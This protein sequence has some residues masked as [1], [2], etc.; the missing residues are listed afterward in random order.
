MSFT[1]QQP[2]TAAARAK[3]IGALAL[4]A[5]PRHK[6]GQHLPR[7]RCA[8]A[9]LGVVLAATCGVA[10]AQ[11]VVTNGQVITANGSYKIPDGVGTVTFEATGA[12]GG[13]GGRAATST[14][15]GGR[16]G[17]G[18][19]VRTS[20]ASAGGL[21]FAV[22]VGSGGGAGVNGSYSS[23][24]YCGTNGG[25][26]TAT[27][28]TAN[29]ATFVS[30]AGGGGGGRAC[31]TNGTTTA[32][33]PGT[34][35]TCGAGSY[36]LNDPSCTSSS[37]N[38][39]GAGAISYPP[40]INLTA[41]ASSGSAGSI[42]VS[43]T[44]A[45]QT[46]A[47]PSLP[48][49]AVLGTGVPL[50]ATSSF[51]G[52]TFSYVG[53]TPGVC[54]V[55]N[56]QLTPTGWGDCS[57]TVQA[58]GDSG[59]N[60][61]SQSCTASVTPDYAVS[62]TVT[63]LVGAGAT[64][65]IANNGAPIAQAGNGQ[66]WT[67]G[68][69][70]G[71]YN[72]TA[73]APGHI[74]QVTNGSGTLTG[75]MPQAVTGV[76][77]A[78]TPDTY[79]LSGTISGAAGPLELQV[80]S[81]PHVLT[82]SPFTLYSVLGHGSNYP[83]S[84]T[85]PATQ[86][87]LVSPSSTGIVNGPVSNV[88]I[89]CGYPLNVAVSGLNES[90]TLVLQNNGANG[91]TVI[92]DGPLSFGWLPLGEAYAISVQTQ[93]QGQT[94]TVDAASAS[95]AM[96][97][98]L[99]VPVVCV[100]N[101]GTGDQ[102]DNSGTWT[103]PPGV[104]RVTI[105]VAG[106]GGGGGA[107]IGALFGSA[108]GGNGGN[109]GLATRLNLPVTPGETFRFQVG[110]G[111]SGTGTSGGTTYLYR[112]AASTPDTAM[113]LGT[114]GAGGGNATSYQ[115]P[116][117]LFPT[118][119]PGTLGQHGSCAPSGAY[120]SCTTTGGPGGAGGLPG[121]PPQPS[122][123]GDKGWVKFTTPQPT[124]ASQSITCGT[125]SK[126]WGDADFDFP[127]ATVLPGTAGGPIGTL[128][129]SN[130]GGAC[131]VA[132]G[133]L[134]ITGAGICTYSATA[135]G[136][137]GVLAQAV[138]SCTVNI[139][140]AATSLSIGVPS[141]V[142]AGQTSTQPIV[143]A[144]N[145]PLA[146]DETRGF[147]ATSGICTVDANTKLV[148]GVLPG[149]CVV[150][151]T[152]SGNANL[153]PSASNPISID[154][155]P[156]V[157]TVSGTVTGLVGGQSVSVSNGSTTQTGGNFS[158]GVTQGGSYSITATA[159]HHTC[160]PAIGG[161]VN[162]DVANLQIA[163]QPLKYSIGGTV[164][165][166][167]A[168]TP[169]TVSLG[170]ATQ[171]ATNGTFSFANSVN[172]NS[173][174]SVSATATGY[175]C[176]PAT[177]T[178]NGDVV[179]A[180]VACTANK[181]TLGYTV[182]GLANGNTVVLSLGGVDKTHAANGSDSYTNALTH[183]QPYALTVKTQPEGQ[184][185]IV[186]ANGSG[187]S[188][189]ADVTGVTVA[190]VTAQYTISATVSGL[191]ASSALV[192]RNNGGD[193][194]SFNTN[195][196]QGFATKVNHNS[197]YAVTVQTAP[198]GYTCTV[199]NGSGTATADVGNVTVACTA[200]PRTVG[201][202]VSGLTG[203]AQV[204]LGNP[205]TSSQTLGNGPFSFATT[206]GSAY[207]I[208]A[209]NPAGHTCSVANGS[210]TVSTDVAN[211]QVL[212]QAHTFTLTGA[213]QPAVGGNVNCPAQAVAY[214]DNASCTATAQTGWRFKAFVAASACTRTSGTEGTTCEIDNVQANHTVTAQ[215]EPY[216]AGTTVPAS[217]NGG[218]A[219]ATFTGGGAS[220][221]FDTSASTAFVAAPATLPAGQTMPQGM[222]RF[223]LV[224]CDTSPVTMSVTWPQAVQG[225]SKW[226]KAAAG[227]AP[228]HFPPNGVAVNG[229]T[230]SF[231]VQDGQLGDD[232]WTVNGEIVDPVGGTVPLAAVAT[233]PTPVPTLG[234]WALV[235]LSMLAAALGMGVLRRRAANN[236]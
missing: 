222:L 140:K 112:L 47:C 100:S 231:T 116:G 204:Q 7:W 26:G 149:L 132:N 5:P 38:N 86:T 41:N 189:T 37:S 158:F 227:A 70:E 104:T 129:Y 212:C 175:S 17:A 177:G 147:T 117:D 233:N 63:G 42:K 80:G 4:Q 144:F 197:P 124:L 135:T 13:G 118:G 213:A 163:C 133:K 98:G 145:P 206:Y 56:G 225:L 9:A 46:L 114:G 3:A 170:S 194:L 166:L 64:A 139:A 121:L 27:Q 235:L 62:G 99:V 201:G 61:A 19:I 21:V 217:G 49:L 73:T 34:K 181:Y 35:G 127:A 134:H 102:F 71:G 29:T 215:F 205:N 24:T 159:P 229:N 72:I 167:P 161:P 8:L 12:G 214:G 220:C 230:T 119:V 183:G 92:A 196:T 200:Q 94:C 54:T 74:C 88:Q 81:T 226:G 30:A 78:C 87:C 223:K 216:F 59:T 186:P 103:V 91:Q 236:Y 153:M 69:N 15:G 174:Y 50:A 2:V 76:A 120:T 232:D 219:S 172:Y 126:T 193:D 58:T 79:H 105:E 48:R 165:G 178:V 192:L 173:P 90:R 51:A 162:A 107:H 180:V 82:A 187:S 106:G 123:P 45:D 142:M 10:T 36:P 190:C 228:T 75:T 101:A 110:S 207:A 156:R 195:S 95:G 25:N 125:A 131:S 28:A 151:A 209:T 160:T 23:G 234:Q 32:G 122:A 14:N 224:G 109:G 208:T 22:T 202:T 6:P 176:T 191:P 168:D 108:A 18:A 57:Y 152:R 20:R 179:G 31:T 113:L 146:A 155:V 136:V 185:C 199:A 77:V 148:T 143:V 40:P 85:A 184:T 137:A 16:G 84:V 60:A 89:A 111:G 169:A 210:G 33:T 141:S 211:V 66:A 221:R 188:A 164:T 130:A 115:N 97:A 67:G 138:Q 52:A 93:P 1:P 218:P 53:G 65:S 43:W 154:V 203:N 150:Q 44:M 157:F 11:T 171:A 198:N 83:L 128:G 39:G 68:I 182:S 96:A 55:G